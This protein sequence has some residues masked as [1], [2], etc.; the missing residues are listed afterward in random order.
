MTRSAAPDG[1]GWRWDIV[2]DGAPV[3]MVLLR[4]CA[5]QPGTGRLIWEVDERARGRG[6]ASQAA[7][8]VRAQAFGELGLNRLEAHIQ[9]GNGASAGVAR[10]AGLR[11]DPRPDGVPDDVLVFAADRR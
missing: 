5:R 11:E 4:R 10:A 1:R 3:G 8:Q 9:A 6:V 2:D 7:R